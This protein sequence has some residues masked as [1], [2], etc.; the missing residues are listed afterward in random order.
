M[1][2]HNNGLYEEFNSIL[3]D[4]EYH[5]INTYKILELLGT[6]YVFTDGNSDN[7][8]R[9]HSLLNC[10]TSLQFQK[11]TSTFD[12]AKNE[13]TYS[14]V[15]ANFCRQRICPMCQYRKAQKQFVQ[16]YKIVQ[17]LESNY[18]FIHL[19]LTI[20]NANDGLE[21][22]KNIHKLYNG[23]NKLMKYA[24]VK[25]VVKGALRCLEISY[26][27]ENNS[28]HPH[29]HCLLVVNPSYFHDT[30]SYISFDKWQQLWTKAQGSQQLLQVSVRAIKY[31]DYKG[32]AE[33]CKYCI[34]PLKLDEGED[35]QHQRMLLTLWHTLKGTRFV[36]RYGVIKDTYKKLFIDDDDDSLIDNSYDEESP[37]YFFSWNTELKQYERS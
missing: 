20:P 3:K 22:V 30:K 31:G 34:K 13:Y 21:L 8:K 32:V 18:R 7:D 33:V 28:F 19:V 1:K 25:R 4:Y 37:L 26:N 36:Q 2:Q 17:E 35:W 14:L 12:G 6:D 24:E 27:Y 10:G 23:Y 5:K 29:L 9:Y 11:I 15:G 16:M